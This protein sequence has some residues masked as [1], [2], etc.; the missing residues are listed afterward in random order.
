MLKLY[1]NIFL[2]LLLHTSLFAQDDDPTQTPLSGFV[3]MHAHPRDD[4]AFGTQLFYGA[5]YGNPEEAL[6]NCKAGHSKN[7]FRSVLAAQTEQQNN[8]TWKDGKAGYPD[9]ATWPAWC[10]TLHQQMWIDWIERAHQGGLSI[11]VALA[12]SSHTIASAAKSKGPYDDAQVLINCIQGIKDLVAYSTFME[13]ALT[14]EDVRRIV[15]N[16][17]LAV[18]LGTEMDNIGNFYSPADQYKAKF[19][20]S[21]TNEQ[22]K[23]ELDKLW[24]LGVRYI[25][26]VHLNNTIF[27]GSALANST[28]NVANKFVTGKEFI[29]EQISTKESGIGFRLQH[30]AIGLNG[31]AKMFMPLLLPKNINPARK[32][33]Y[34]Y[35]DTIPGFGHRNSLGITD[36]GRFG[37]NYMMQKGFLIDIDH[38]SEKMANEVLQ[39]AVTN[40]YPVNSG[41]NGLRGESDTENVRTIQQYQLLKQ[42]GGMVGLGHCDSANG[43]VKSFREVGQIMGF[44]NMAIGTDVGGFKALPKPDFSVHVEYDSTLSP[45]KTGNRT[46]DI[47]IDGVAHYGLLPDYIRSWDE[48]G[49]TPKEK[50]AF[51]SSAEYF[52]RMW[53]KCELRKAQIP[54]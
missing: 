20:P 25:F 40:D 54:H 27:G 46:W 15:S 23:E 44:M 12:V 41:H 26:P 50:S 28:L 30:P 1:A 14:P 5:P 22:I 18:V 19:N 8:P 42:I 2:S 10:T 53:E 34:S 32:D 48:A 3:D 39:M 43:F 31:A 7:L 35:W 37:L 38:M 6:G 13:I 21:P 47:N 33:N 4:L 9:F 11:M 52:T 29:P 17:K 24:E 45:C 49:M 51:M 16:G 36:K